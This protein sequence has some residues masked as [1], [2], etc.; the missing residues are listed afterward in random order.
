ML[1]K[2]KEAT[3]DLPVKIIV[4]GDNEDKDCINYKTVISNN[5]DLIKGYSDFVEVSMTVNRNDSISV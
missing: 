2:V 3:K 1:E 4:I 5:G